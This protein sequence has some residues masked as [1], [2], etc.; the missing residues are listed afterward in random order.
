MTKRICSALT[1]LFGDHVEL[2]DCIRNTYYRKLPSTASTFYGGN[3]SE[4]ALCLVDV[5]HCLAA[6]IPTHFQPRR[7]RLQC[8]TVKSIWMLCMSCDFRILV[9]GGK[10][11]AGIKRNGKIESVGENSVKF[12]QNCLVRVLHVLPN[13]ACSNER[14]YSL[15]CTPLALYVTMGL[16]IQKPFVYCLFLRI[17]VECLARN[18]ELNFH[19]LNCGLWSLGYPTVTPHHSGLQ[20][21]EL[22]RCT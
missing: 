9:I 20:C 8:K 19:S 13:A 2:G 16:G 17:S 4:V 12:T 22:M 14:Q 6:L 3:R 15:L 10:S 1:L 5:E 18:R 7:R 21:G 11:E